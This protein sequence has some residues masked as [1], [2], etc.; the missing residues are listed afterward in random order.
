[1]LQFLQLY[2]PS[3]PSPDALPTHLPRLAEEEVAS[4]QVHGLARNMVFIGH[5]FGACC[6]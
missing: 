2:L 6:M 4:R 3:H 5:S 1:M